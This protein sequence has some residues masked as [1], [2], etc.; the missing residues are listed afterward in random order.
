MVRWV[1]NDNALILPNDKLEITLKRN[2]DGTNDG[3]I[4][5]WRRPGHAYCIAKAPRYS[6]DK[7]WKH[8]AT[9]LVNAIHATSASAKDR[10]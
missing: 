2:P 9:L 3:S 1:M 8:N 5:V 4:I 7:E 10:Q 6:T